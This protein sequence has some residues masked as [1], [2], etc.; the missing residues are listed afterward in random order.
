VVEEETMNLVDGLERIRGIL[1]ANDA[2][3]ASIEAVDTILANAGRM[4]GDSARAQS[5]LQITKMLMRTPAANQN[6]DVYNDLARIEQQL[7]IRAN[8]LAQERAA[9]VD[10]PVPK[11]KKFYKAQKEREKAAKAKQGG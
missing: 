6:V 4:G 9:E 10:R 11:D 3:P 7:T 5:L 2:D 1:E 8:A